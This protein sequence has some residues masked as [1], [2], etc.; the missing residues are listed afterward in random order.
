M[1]PLIKNWA[2]P[3]GEAVNDFLHVLEDTLPHDEVWPQPYD[4]LYHFQVDVLWRKILT[5]NLGLI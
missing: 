5:P 3:D 4:H 1:V 2:S